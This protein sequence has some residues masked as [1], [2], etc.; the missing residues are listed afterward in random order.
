MPIITLTTD[1][2]YNNWF[3]GCMKGV[4][5][6]IA[7][8]AKIIDLNHGI[9]KFNISEASF[10]LTAS[11]DY[12]P[13]KSIHIVVVDPGVGSNR[14][15]IIAITEKCVFVAPDN[16]VLSPFL[17]K[18]D[19]K[20]YHLA[21]KKFFLND[22]S[23]TF[24][25]RDI[26]APVAAHIANGIPIN[27]IGTQITNPIYLENDFFIKDNIN[28]AQSPINAKIIFIDSF[29]NLITNVH[30]SMITDKNDIKIK[31][32]NYEISK[33]SKNYHCV[34]KK[35]AVALIGS[36]GFLEIAVNQGNASTFFK[37]GINNPL[38]IIIND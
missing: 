27:K 24:H 17:K 34:E 31:L 25:A 9:S 10:S 13:D 14:R 18:P 20:I 2:G 32:N 16:G 29:G 6:S 28:T 11:I 15:P 38:E 12:F 3:A 21:N 36:S 37:A 22:I 26:F 8:D 1:F 23:Q 30:K 33:I 5:A 4:I 35:S 19:V 7:P